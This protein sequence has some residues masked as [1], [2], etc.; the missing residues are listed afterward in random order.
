VLGIEGE[1][2]GVLGFSLAALLLLVMP[3]LDRGAAVGRPSKIIT[4]AAVLTVLYLI[5]FTIYGYLAA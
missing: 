5:I 2:L 4:A 1:M 3:F